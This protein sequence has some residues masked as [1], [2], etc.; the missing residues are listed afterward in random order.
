MF[1]CSFHQLRENTSS[2]QRAAS[3]DIYQNHHTRAYQLAQK[4]PLIL[5]TNVL[6][7]FLSATL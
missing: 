2:Q 7:G 6:L 3:R 5:D 4:Y 1:E